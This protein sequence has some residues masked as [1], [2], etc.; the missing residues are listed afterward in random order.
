MRGVWSHRPHIVAAVGGVVLVLAL[1]A[2]GG[3]EDSADEATSS[4]AS[5]S[6]SA[7]TA[8]PS[9]SSTTPES[10]TDASPFSGRSGGADQPVLAVK[11]D[12]TGAAQ[13]HAGLQAA[14]LV[15]VEEVEWGLTRLIAVFS[16]EI[17]DVVGPVRSARVSDIDILAPFGGIAFAYSGA[18]SKLLPSLAQAA[19]LDASANASYAGWFNDAARP[20]PVDHMIRA[21]DVLGVFDE[22]A[23]ARDIGLEFSAEPPAGGEPVQEITATWPSSSVGFRWD[24]E[25]GNYV[26]VIDGSDSR[27]SEGG[28]Q[29]AATVVIQSVEQS[30]S[31]YGDKFGG[32][33]PFIETVG[34]GSAV[35]LRDGRMW[36]VTWERPSL[37]EGTRFLLPDGSPMPFAVGQEWI[38]LLDSDREPVLR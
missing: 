7:S 6:V 32:V 13:P 5:P 18:Q 9:P 8:S 35:V 25:V 2:C 28:P 37:S 1:A 38:V 23:L 30:D 26:V 36:P 12:N 4:S 15:Y 19:F 27:S 14:D 11:I 24:P 22:A 29:R 16:S 10:I 3:G 33:T 31:G 20:S 17:P 21:N 34:S